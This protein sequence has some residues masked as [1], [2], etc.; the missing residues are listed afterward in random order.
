[1]EDDAPVIYGLEFQ[2]RQEGPR[3]PAVCRARPAR[4]PGAPCAAEDTEAAGVKDLAIQDR[5]RH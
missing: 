1:M 2:V 4:V 5:P 3:R